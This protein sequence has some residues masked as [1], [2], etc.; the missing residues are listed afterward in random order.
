MVGK[1][2]WVFE[3]VFEAV[4]GFVECLAAVE[5]FPASGAIYSTA[6]TIPCGMWLLRAIGINPDD[7]FS[8]MDRHH[9]WGEKRGS[10]EDH[11]RSAQRCAQ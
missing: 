11:H 5:F 8:G 3:D 2:S 6:G 7:A 1:G 10:P 4:T 9:L